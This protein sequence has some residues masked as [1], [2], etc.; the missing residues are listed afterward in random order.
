MTFE[1]FLLYLYIINHNIVY[2][3]PSFENKIAAIDHK[4][5]NYLFNLKCI[6]HICIYIR[7]Y[8]YTL[9]VCSSL[10]DF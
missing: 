3:L 1:I 5:I 2:P 4:S 8:I 9:L 7:I 6:P 10:E